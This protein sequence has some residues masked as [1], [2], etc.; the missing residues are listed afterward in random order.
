LDGAGWLARR[1]D[2]VKLYRGCDFCLNMKTLN[3]LEAIVCRYVPS[4]YFVVNPPDQ[5]IEG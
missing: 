2:L 4:R 1:S 5:V 3:Q